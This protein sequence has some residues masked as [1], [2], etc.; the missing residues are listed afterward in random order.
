[1][2]LLSVTGFPYRLYYKLAGKV[3][4]GELVFLLLCMHVPCHSHHL[5]I[6]WQ[7]TR[8]TS[9][10]WT[11]FFCREHDSMQSKHHLSNQI[12]P[13][14]SSP[15][16]MLWA[17]VYR[18]NHNHYKTVSSRSVSSKGYHGQWSWNVWDSNCIYHTVHISYCHAINEEKQ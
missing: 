1:M 6:Q 11:C 14:C 10:L 15:N 17:W 9:R 13:H 8:N 12:V 18:K 4:Y 5:Q 3:P 16:T 7:G 2:Q